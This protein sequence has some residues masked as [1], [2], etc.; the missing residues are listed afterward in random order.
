MKTGSVTRATGVS[1]TWAAPRSGS[2]GAVV[3]G[4]AVVA[5]AVVA[6]LPVVAGALVPAAV[7]AVAAL[8]ALAALVAEAAAGVVGSAPL[9]L[10][11]SLLHAASSTTAATVPAATSRL[12]GW[13]G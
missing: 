5:A 7:V 12:T 2:A 13:R 9:P 1:L 6:G 11:L 8:A 10:P 4:A 3:V